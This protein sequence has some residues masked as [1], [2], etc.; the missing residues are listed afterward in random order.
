MT[1]PIVAKKSFRDGHVSIGVRLKCG[2][3][4]D[5]A[6][7]DAGCE[8]AV[9]QARE[10]ARSL[11]ELADE[12]EARA[13]KKAAADERRAKWRDREIAAGR[14]KVMRVSDVFG[15]RAG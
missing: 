11:I 15:R 1:S 12:A 4:G 3:Y 10:L 5:T 2:A 8:L 14:M 6:R 13:V 9:A 7:I